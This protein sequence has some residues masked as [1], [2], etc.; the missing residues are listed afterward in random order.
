VLKRAQNVN[1]SEHHGFYSVSVENYKDACRFVRMI[2]YLFRATHCEPDPDTVF[3]QKQLRIANCTT[4]EQFTRKA[5]GA[6]GP[7]TG[8]PAAPPPNNSETTSLRALLAEPGMARHF[9]DEFG[10]DPCGQE[11]EDHPA[12]SPLGARLRSFFWAVAQTPCSIRLSCFKR[13]S[14]T[15]SFD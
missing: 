15:A 13:S 5:W 2:R 4:A 1:E 10:V 9:F 7:P 11:G 3:R 8:W 12:R 14:Q 6:I